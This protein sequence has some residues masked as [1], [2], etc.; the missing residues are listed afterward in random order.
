MVSADGPFA[1]LEGWLSRLIY[2]LASG[3]CCFVLLM[4]VRPRS[5]SFSMD[6]VDALGVGMIRKD[7]RLQ[8][9]W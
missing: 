4:S 1:L 5:K 3:F 2:Q 8:Q 6:V 7:R 9:C